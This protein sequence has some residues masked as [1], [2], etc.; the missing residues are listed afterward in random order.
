ML[1]FLTSL[2]KF[3]EFLVDFSFY[4]EYDM[5]HNKTMLFFLTS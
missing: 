3:S 5:K 2:K 4:F 1:D